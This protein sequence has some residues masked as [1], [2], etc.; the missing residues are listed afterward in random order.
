MPKVD[1]D[2]DTSDAPPA[3]PVE[4]GRY[5]SLKVPVGK[6]GYPAYGETPRTSSA[7]RTK[8]ILTRGEPT[9]RPTR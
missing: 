4:E 5:T 7:V 1:R 3:V 8:A 9:P 6:L 2:A